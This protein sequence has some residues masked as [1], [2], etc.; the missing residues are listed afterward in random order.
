M[1]G[2]WFTTSALRAVRHCLFARSVWLGRAGRRRHDAPERVPGERAALECMRR[3]G[4]LGCAV[5]CPRGAGPGASELGGVRPAREEASLG[6]AALLLKCAVNV[7]AT[8]RLECVAWAGSVLFGT[9]GRGWECDVWVHMRASVCQCER[10]QAERRGL[11]SGSSRRSK[12]G[13]TFQLHPLR[14]D[15][16]P[17]LT[18]ALHQSPACC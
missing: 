11:R 10:G 5:V 4:D 16:S 13:G 17:L 12:G 18:A 14:K 8:C 9:R 2:C 6:S 7:G 1:C 3:F 15:A